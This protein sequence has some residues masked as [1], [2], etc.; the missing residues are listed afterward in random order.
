MRKIAEGIV[1]ARKVFNIR[2][3]WTPDEDTLPERFFVEHLPDDHE[4]S[5]SREALK[6]GIAA[7]NLQRGWDEHGWVRGGDKETGR[8]GDKETGRGTFD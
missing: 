5:L 2:A 4:A 6:L 7:Y 1:T 3:G 8:G